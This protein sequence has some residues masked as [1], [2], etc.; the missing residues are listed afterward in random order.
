MISKEP[1]AGRWAVAGNGVYFVNGQNVKYYSFAKHVTIPVGDIPRDAVGPAD[2]ATPN[3]TATADGR[4][5]AW[6]QRDHVGS[7]LTL[8]ENFR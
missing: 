7:D 3:F 4:W 2:D 6:S 8:V 1:R 5:I